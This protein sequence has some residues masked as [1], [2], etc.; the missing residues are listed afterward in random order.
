MELISLMALDDQNAER[1][2]RLRRRRP[3]HYKVRMQR[4]QKTRRQALA[5]YKLAHG[6]A[7]CGYRGHPEALHF[8]HLDGGDKVNSVSRLSTYKWSAVLKEIEKCQVLCANCHA[9]ATAERRHVA[10]EAKK[11]EKVDHQLRL[12]LA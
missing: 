3:E 10:R 8:D 11:K 2:R 5:E 4:F 1:N 6:C 7:V 12:R 9:I